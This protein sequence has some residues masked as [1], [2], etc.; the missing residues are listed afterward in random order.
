MIV[1]TVTCA[2]NLHEAA[3]MAKSVKRHM[4]GSKVIVCLAE[5]TMHP[6]ALTIRHFDQV[7]LAASLGIPN[8]PHYLFKYVLFEGVTSMKPH[9]LKYLMSCYP[10]ERQFLYLDSD[11]KMFRFPEELAGAMERSSI[12]LVPQQIEAESLW[13]EHLFNGSLNSGLLGV[14]R[15]E[16]ASRF[17]GWWAE[18]TYHYGFFDDQFFA[19][20][21]WLDLAAA[22][23]DVHVFK[24]PGYNVAFW[25]L[26]EKARRGLH[27]AGGELHLTDKPLCIFHYSHYE[28]FLP[29][30]FVKLGI[31]PQGARAIMDSYGR[32]LA[33][34]GIQDIAL[35]HWS[36]DFFDSGEPILS[37]SR[38]KFKNNPAFRIAMPNPYAASNS[39]F[40]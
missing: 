39:A 34:T 20:Q 25:N 5:K 28:S 24:H 15:S 21:K 36:Y 19:D 16:E 18:R 40:G 7:V 26:H 35:T 9:L 13:E 37:E 2:D 11:M 31:D 10:N 22:F 30:C 14:T 29:N 3:V 8:F 23:F 4:N 38:V 6:A 27:V 12:V 17:I 32:E 33:E 1:C